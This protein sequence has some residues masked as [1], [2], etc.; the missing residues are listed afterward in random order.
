MFLRQPRRPRTGTVHDHVPR[1]SPPDVCCEKDVRQ[2]E[3][4]V[5]SQHPLLLPRS[6]RGSE[7]GVLACFQEPVFRERGVHSIPRLAG[8]HACRDGESPPR[9][10]PCA[11][12]EQRREEG[13]GRHAMELKGCKH[14][15]KSVPPVPAGPLGHVEGAQHRLPPHSR[16]EPHRHAEGSLLVVVAR[17]VEGHRLGGRGEEERDAGV[18]RAA[19]PIGDGE[20]L[21]RGA[22]GLPPPGPGVRGLVPDPASGH[23]AADGCGHVCALHELLRMVLAVVLVQ[24]RQELAGRV[25]VSCSHS[26]QNALL[27]CQPCTLQRACQVDEGALLVWGEARGVGRVISQLL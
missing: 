13:V 24:P 23:L 1:H 25:L 3:R 18:V 21:G 11:G 9:T 19:V 5:R 22:H 10:P 26:L 20:P 7:R 6:A 2:L 12:G 15:L 14:L 8:W 17:R 27:P 16:Q 4:G